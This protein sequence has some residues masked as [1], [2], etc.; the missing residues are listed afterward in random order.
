VFTFQKLHIMQHLGTV[1]AVRLLETQTLF[2]RNFIPGEKALKSFGKTDGLLSLIQHGPHW[3][4][5]V[6]QFFYCWV[7]IRYRGNVSTEPLPSNDMGIFTEPLPSNDRGIHRHTHTHTYTHRQQR[8]L[9]SLLYFFK[10]KE[11]AI[12]RNTVLA[13]RIFT[14]SNIYNKAENLGLDCHPNANSLFRTKTNTCER[15]WKRHP[16]NSPYALLRCAPCVRFCCFSFT[17][18]CLTP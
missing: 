4:R 6:Q 17:V 16:V 1:A 3:K 11:T 2:F 12:K 14:R 8:D 10:N 13:L 7:C 15:K 9:I 18:L 5:G